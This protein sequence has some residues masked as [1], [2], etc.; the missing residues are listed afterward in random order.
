MISKDQLQRAG[1]LSIT[2]AIFTI[3]AVVLS[4]YLDSMEGAG[5]KFGQAILMI[6]S[7]GLFVYVLSS[8]KRLLNERFRFHEVDLSISYLL[9]GNLSLTLFQLLSLV[10]PEF[11]SA[12]AILS[13][14]AYIFFGI[15]SLMFATRLQRLPD[16]LYGLLKPY[17]RLTIISGACFITVILLPLGILA[18]AV[19]DVLLGLI[20]FRAAEQSPS[21]SEVFSTPIE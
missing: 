2:N 6:V 21:P 11:E 13:I 9:W 1:W 14:L 8:L 19:T 5:A 12:V 16:P 4:F 3:P 20:F 15:L 18:G 10:N 7:L 17:C